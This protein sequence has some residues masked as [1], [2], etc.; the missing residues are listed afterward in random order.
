M[1]PRNLLGLFSAHKFYLGETM[2]GVFYLIINVVLFV[3]IIVPFVFAVIC[4]IEGIIYLT[5]S[6]ADFAEKYARE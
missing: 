2:W 6:D 4:L 3:T 1:S 5:Y